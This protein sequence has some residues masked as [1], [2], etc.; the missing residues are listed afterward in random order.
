MTEIGNMSNALSTV[1]GCVFIFVGGWE[2]A[3]SKDNNA[4]RLM[5]LTLC[6]LG[7]LIVK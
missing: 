1:A 6:A 2:A 3:R 4:Q 5:G 7:L